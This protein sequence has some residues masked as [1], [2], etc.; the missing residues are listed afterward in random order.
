MCRGFG[1]DA[2]DAFFAPKQRRALRFIA[3]WNTSR[4]RLLLIPL[5][6]LARAAL[7][8][9]TRGLSDRVRAVI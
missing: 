5:S 1:L 4:D 7:L 9:R 8:V 3:K 2:G 6:A